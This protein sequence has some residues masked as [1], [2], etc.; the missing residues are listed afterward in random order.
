MPME[1]FS[2]HESRQKNE[3]VYLASLFRELGKKEGTDV[4]F[5]MLEEDLRSAG[6][7]RADMIEVAQVLY[8]PTL[9]CRS[10]LFT[11]VI[12]LLIERKHISV[13]NKRGEANMCRTERGSGFRTAM[14]EGFSGKDVGSMTKVVLT[15]SEECLVS[16]KP[17][18][19]ESLLWQTK[20]ETARV[21]IQ[22]EGDITFEDIQMV[23]FRFPARHFPQQQMTEEELDRFENG[24]IHFIVRHFISQ[25]DKGTTVM[26]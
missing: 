9:Y 26:Q 25:K 19:K 3:A 20:P 5:E 13:A 4:V 18:E 6:F 2:S 1:S 7:E 24:D 17:I 21:S 16:K 15:F 22:G 11:K 8:N 12:D 10:E 14:L 23:S